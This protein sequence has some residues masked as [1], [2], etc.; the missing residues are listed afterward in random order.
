[1]VKRKVI[2]VIVLLMFI[3]GCATFSIGKKVQNAYISKA[4]AETIRTSAE[5][6]HAGGVMSN[7]DFKKLKKVWNDAR[8]AN[9]KIIDAMIEGLNSGADPAE[10]TAYKE[11][12]ATYQALSQALIQ[13]ALDLELI[14]EEDL[15][16]K[17]E[18]DVSFN[19][20]YPTFES[21]KS[22]RAYYTIYSR[23]L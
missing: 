13:M 21:R 2:P 11:N 1:M 15:L 18:E 8:L 19:Q 12:L 6:A 3:S 5:L 9:N 23:A 4:L 17:G 7:E 20:S 10:S 22:V 14:T 16:I